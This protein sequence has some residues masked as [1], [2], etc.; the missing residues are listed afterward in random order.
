MKNTDIKIGEYWIVK[1]NVKDK[2]RCYSGP[3]LVKHYSSVNKGFSCIVVNN[4][5]DC[6]ANMYSGSLFYTKD[7]VRISSKKEFLSYRL[8]Y[9]NRMKK[10]IANQLERV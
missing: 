4:I 2:D 1:Y 9:I 10:K 3:V 5:E 8:K 6:Y 7:F